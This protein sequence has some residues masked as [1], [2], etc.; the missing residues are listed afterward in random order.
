[1]G[2]RGKMEKV[3]SKNRALVRLR[4]AETKA[5]TE[6]GHS[7]SFIAKTLGIAESTV[8]AYRRQSEGDTKEL[9]AAIKKHWQIEDFKLSELTRNKLIE[10]I[11]TAKF[12]DLTGLYKIS[13]ELQTP[14]QSIN[15]QANL[16]VVINNNK[17]DVSIG[18]NVN[19]NE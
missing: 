4:T 1:M 10:K 2:K 17:D 15:T 9:T 8:S 6:E 14:K 16:Q 12:Y 3:A 19:N 13:R 11:D 7:I 5:L 18:E